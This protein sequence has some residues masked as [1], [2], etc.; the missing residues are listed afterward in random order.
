MFEVVFTIRY[1]IL[2]IMQNC[3]LAP[4][5]YNTLPGRH[6]EVVQSSVFLF[7]CYDGFSPALCSL[8]HVLVSPLIFLS[9]YEF[10]AFSVLRFFSVLLH[11]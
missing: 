11:Y 9:W 7:V 1:V 8:S 6:F 5:S 10:A 2:T 3:K 4:E